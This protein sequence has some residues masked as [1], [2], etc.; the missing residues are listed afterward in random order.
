MSD[1][2]KIFEDLGFLH[3]RTYINSGNVIFES[4]MSDQRE[5]EV[6]IENALAKRYPH[7]TKVVVRNKNEIAAVIRNL[8]KNWSSDRDVRHNVIF[9]RHSIDSKKIVADLNPKPDIEEVSYKPGV[10]YWSAAVA[11][12]TRTSMLKLASKEIYKEM[13][14]RNLNTTKKIF[15][16]MNT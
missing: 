16:L 9:L 6:V 13:T 12:L 14:I 1:L 11:T 8:P 3:V 15:E 4:D 2:K 10:L 7:G 5:I